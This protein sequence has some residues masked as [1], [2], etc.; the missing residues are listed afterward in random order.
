MGMGIEERIEWEK[1]R[2]LDSIAVVRHVLDNLERDMRKPDG[3]IPSLGALRFAGEQ[4]DL[5]C[6]RV[7]LLKEIKREGL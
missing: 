2:L 7:A 5:G 3:T 6:A 1:A 4:I